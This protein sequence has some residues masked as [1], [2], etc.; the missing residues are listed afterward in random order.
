MQ[1]WCKA[2]KFFLKSNIWP[3]PK[4]T[5]KGSSRLRLRPVTTRWRLPSPEQEGGAAADCEGHVDARAPSGC[6]PPSPLRAPRLCPGP[7]RGSAADER[8]P[9]LWL[10]GSAHR[11]RRGTRTQPVGEYLRRQPTGPHAGTR[12]PR[13]PRTRARSRSFGAAFG[14]GREAAAPCGETPSLGFSESLLYWLP[15]S[16][17]KRLFFP[18]IQLR[19]PRGQRQGRCT[20]SALRDQG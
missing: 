4:P 10:P 9:A 16:G 15:L 19:E 14:R 17:E 3:F 13:T 20:G 8:S 5:E 7:R 18:A 11:D 6:R 2:G 12:R 1:R